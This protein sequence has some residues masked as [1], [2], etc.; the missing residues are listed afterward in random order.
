MATDNR[1]CKTCPPP[2][3]DSYTSDVRQQ[4]DALEVFAARILDRVRELRESADRLE[5]V[6]GQQ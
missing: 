5:V 3:A 2:P 1:T 6:R 4:A